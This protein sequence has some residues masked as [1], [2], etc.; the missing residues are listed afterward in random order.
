M[1]NAEMSRQLNALSEVYN[2]AN[3][4]C[5]ADFELRS[6]WARYICVLGAGFLENALKAIYSDFVSKAA[7]EPVANY[8]MWSLSRT[9]N[10]KTADFLETARR[11]RGI[12]AE[13]LSL[14]TES[15]GRGDAINSI[16]ANRHLIA[17]GKNS[18][19]TM[20]QVKTYLDKAVEVI[21]FIETQC[22]R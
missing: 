20:V 1:L 9:R 14:F 8:A 6:H 22:H 19:I 7:A 4:A 17:H 2:K 13:Q 12:W 15:D 5:S 11:F 10:P 3:A 18:G 16:M 21:E